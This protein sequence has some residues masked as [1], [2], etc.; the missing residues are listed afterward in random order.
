M[1]N[2]GVFK[3]ASLENFAGKKGSGADIKKL[4]TDKNY[5]AIVAY[6]E[7]ETAKFLKLY[8]FISQHLPNLWQDEYKPK[9]LT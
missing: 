6:I 1:F 4:Y 3:G 9:I 7:D 8:E 2:G 5:P